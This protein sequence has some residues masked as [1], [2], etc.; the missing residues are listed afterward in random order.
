MCT[1]VLLIRQGHAW[2]LVLA[3][4]RDEMENRPWEMPAEYWPGICGGRDS[5]AGS[6]PAGF[7]AATCLIG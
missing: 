3:A 6:D 5:L 2:P 1:V 4:N 7:S